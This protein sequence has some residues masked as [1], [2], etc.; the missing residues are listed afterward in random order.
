M[1]GI[2]SKKNYLDSETVPK[3]GRRGEHIFIIRIVP[4]VLV[5][6][7]WKKN[8]YKKLLQMVGFVG[9]NDFK[10][11][12]PESEFFLLTFPLLVHQIVLQ[13]QYSFD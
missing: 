2:L 9:Q 6:G 12:P 11:F 8:P 3:Y 5:G 1:L 10:F 4:L 13:R 7:S